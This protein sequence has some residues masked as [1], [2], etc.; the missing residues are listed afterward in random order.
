MVKADFLKVEKI[1]Q[2]FGLVRLESLL[3]GTKVR[4]KHC[5]LI[6]FAKICRA[7]LAVVKF[8]SQTTKFPDIFFSLTVFAMS[9]KK[10]FSIG[11]FSKKDMRSFD[12]FR[13]V[14]TNV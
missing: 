7:G 3:D 2:T 12:D 10:E 1:R 11:F 9:V 14:V 4:L 13:T 5:L 6:K 8:V